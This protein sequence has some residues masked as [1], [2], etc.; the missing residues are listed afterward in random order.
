[1]EAVEGDAD[2]VADMH[3]GVGAI[4][5]P[6]DH[7]Q[8]GLHIELDVD[9]LKRMGSHVRALEKAMIDYYGSSVY[10]LRKDKAN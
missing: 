7:A 8:S 2:A 6:A 9:A 3:R 1:M 10:K 4:D 5:Q